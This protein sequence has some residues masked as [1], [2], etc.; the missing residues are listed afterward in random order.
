MTMTSMGLPCG[1]GSETVKSGV[2]DLEE[3]F[4]L[5]QSGEVGALGLKLPASGTA[6]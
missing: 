5:P 1:C 2:D 6:C 3:P 4:K